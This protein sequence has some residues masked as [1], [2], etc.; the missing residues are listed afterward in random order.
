[1]EVAEEDVGCY[2][3]LTKSPNNSAKAR[4]SLDEAPSKGLIYFN[5]K[6][7]GSMRLLASESTSIAVSELEASM[8]LYD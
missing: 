1:L 4:P 2:L 3:T 8:A 7:V 6:A 5:C